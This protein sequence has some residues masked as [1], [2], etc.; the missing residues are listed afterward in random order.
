MCDDLTLIK[1]LVVC[2]ITQN[3]RYIDHSFLNWN[4]EDDWICETN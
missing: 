4:R 2:K 1:E 3:R